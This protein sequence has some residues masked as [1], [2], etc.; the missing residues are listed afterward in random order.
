M[1]V[2]KTDFIKV[3]TIGVTWQLKK[4]A[5]IPGIQAMVVGFTVSN[6]FNFAASP[7]DPEATI[8]GSAQGQGGATTGG[9]SYATYS[10]PRQFV[11][12]VRVN[13]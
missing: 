9:I 12:S 6:P 8:S 7:F 10:A 11:G 5:A 3:R 4:L 2:H 1:F 13:F